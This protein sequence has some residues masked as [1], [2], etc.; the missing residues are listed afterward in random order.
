LEAAVER[1]D[2]EREGVVDGADDVRE[3][4]VGELEW[5]GSGVDGMPGIGIYFILV[6]SLPDKTIVFVVLKLSSRF[7][8]DPL[9]FNY[10]PRGPSSAVIYYP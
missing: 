3:A 5:M 6:I 2:G 7:N 4:V 9:T 1:R 10:E 8:G